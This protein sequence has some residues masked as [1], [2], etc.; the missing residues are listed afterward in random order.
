LVLTNSAD[1]TANF[2]TRRLVDASVA[3]IRVDTDA[4]A[5]SI[6]LSATDQGASLAINGANYSPED[7]SH[8]WLR[9]PKPL[10]LEGVPNG[11]DIQYVRQ[12][13]SAALEGFLGAIKKERWINHPAN[14]ACAS[15]KVEQIVRARDF[16]LLVPRTLVTQSK[17]QLRQFFEQNNGDII[18][19]PL[20]GGYVRR[21]AP[22]HDTVIY[23][24]AVSSD[25][26]HQF[27][28]FAACPT[29]FQQRIN[30]AFDV[31]IT[32]VDDDVHVVSLKAT[33]SN[34]VQ[35]L[36]IRRKRMEDV[37]YELI[38]IPRGMRARLL[39]YVRSYNLRFAAID[40]SVNTRGEWIFFEVNPN[41]Q[42]AWMDL[43]GISNISESFVQS[44]RRC[45][46]S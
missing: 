33:E 32:V 11:S 31:R 1:E 29:L 19:K 2:L 17:E 10:L 12:E 28:P 27:Q 41:G 22:R 18:V 16:G 4:F 37:I 7:F 36:D 13:W 20:T 34:G 35:R 6:T 25:D 40:M 26:I 38:E 30:K 44:F 24:N 42:W 14:N 3:F 9:R 45:G 46:K 5:Q 39:S 23:T 43:A 15:H 8:V 21:A